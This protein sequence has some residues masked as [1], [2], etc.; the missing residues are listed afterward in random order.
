MLLGLVLVLAALGVA[1]LIGGPAIL[2]CVSCVLSRVLSDVAGLPALLRLL[3]GAGHARKRGHNGH[4]C[5][6]AGLE[7]SCRHNLT[8]PE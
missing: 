7:P 8:S 6:R 4:N 3:R 1:L 5:Q 2:F